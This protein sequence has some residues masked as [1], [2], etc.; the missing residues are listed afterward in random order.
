[1]G[2]QFDAILAYETWSLCP[3]PSQ[4]NIIQNK[5]PYKIKQKQDESIDRY[6]A[7]LVAKGFDQ[8]SGVDF[9]ETFIPTV[10]TSTI[11]VILALAV[12]FNWSVQQL[13]MSNAFLHGHL[14]EEVY[15]EQPRGFIDSQFPCYVCRLHKSCMV[16]NKHLVLGLHASLKCCWILCLFLPLLTALYLCFIMDMYIFTS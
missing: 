16:L 14:L 6:K 4:H 9:T 11:R 13:D 12:Q 3:R 5:R 8:E 15:M 7:R 10:K 2:D 1:M